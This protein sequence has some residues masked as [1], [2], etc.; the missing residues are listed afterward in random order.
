[1]N[2]GLNASPSSFY[3]PFLFI[4]LSAFQWARP[5]FR[6]ASDVSEFQPENRKWRE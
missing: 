2:C 4:R 3:V 1:L 5:R 6:K